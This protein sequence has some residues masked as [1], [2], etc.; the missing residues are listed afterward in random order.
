ML[1]DSGL[2]GSSEPE[3][4]LVPPLA[5]RSANE[6]LTTPAKAGSGR[7]DH[8]RQ[9]PPAVGEEHGVSDVGGEADRDDDDAE[10]EQELAGAGHQ[11]AAAPPGGGPTGTTA[12]S[13]AF[14]SIW[15]IRP[16]LAQVWIRACLPMPH[17]GQV[18]TSSSRHVEHSVEP[19]G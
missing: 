16:Q 12:R 6:P 11:A 13:S 15:R 7:D 2:A 14:L 1:R 19:L 3:P 10:R 5:A 8:P 9:G 4:K 17:F 18:T